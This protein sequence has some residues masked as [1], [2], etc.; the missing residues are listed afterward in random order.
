MRLFYHYLVSTNMSQFFWVDSFFSSFHVVHSL[1]ESDFL[2]ELPLNPSPKVCE[3][4]GRI[5]YLWTNITTT[6]AEVWTTTKTKLFSA[7]GNVSF[8]KRFSR[9][10]PPITKPAKKAR[11]WLSASLLLRKFCCPT[12]LSRGWR[13]VVVEAVVSGLYPSSY[14]PRQ[15]I[16]YSKHKEGQ[17]PYQK[18]CGGIWILLQ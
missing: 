17:K 15:K 5:F 11:E 14:S 13:R 8:G 3:E 12:F 18:C 16:Q 6:K 10:L 2:P 1:L 4:K 9:R 7:N